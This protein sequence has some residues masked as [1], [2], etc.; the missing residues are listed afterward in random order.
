MS[1]KQV[2]VGTY[3]YEYTGHTGSDWAHNT[4]CKQQLNKHVA[5]AW[6]LQ[7]TADIEMGRQQVHEGLRVHSEDVGHGTWD[8]TGS[9]D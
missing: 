7:V 5:Y 1:T 4:L 2:H 8:I 9:L 6:S 3:K